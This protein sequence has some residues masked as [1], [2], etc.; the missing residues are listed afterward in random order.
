[1][2]KLLTVV[3]LSGL[4]SVPSVVFAQEDGGASWYGI[5]HAGINSAATAGVVDGGS[6]W[7]IKGSS[8]VSEGLT[9]VYQFE[10]SINATNASWGAGRVSYAGLSG[11]FGTLQ[12]GHNWSAT[13]NSVGAITDNSSYF[14]D[15]ETSGRH[16]NMVSY[17]V[18]VENISIQADVTMNNGWGAKSTAADTNTMDGVDTAKVSEDD[19]VDAFELGVSMGLGE[20]GRFAFAHKSHDTAEDVKTNSNWIAGQYTIGSIT[21]Y[22]GFGQTKTENNTTAISG[23]KTDKTTFA[24]IRGS[25]ADTG[26]SYLFQARS[27]KA[28]GNTGGADE[29]A[30]SA[31]DANKHS[32]WMLGLSRSLGG[33]TSVL[34][35]HSDPDQEGKK[36]ASRL[37]LKVVF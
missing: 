4:L 26:V 34:F 11:G 5:L 21:A 29:S 25:I 8:E 18:S 12:F 27:K 14:G 31:V 7:G 37:A 35:E 13:Y 23:Q 19:N 3:C 10:H 33:G 24:G 36:S 22:V 20:S 16:G 30:D 1:M 15:S 6:R 9:A 32:P 2:K 28:K 17:A